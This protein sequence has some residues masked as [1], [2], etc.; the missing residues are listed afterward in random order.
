MQ[1]RPKALF[2]CSPPQWLACEIVAGDKY[3]GCC[4]C[5]HVVAMT[6]IGPVAHPLAVLNCDSAT[7]SIVSRA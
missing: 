7:T 5:H 3:A 2:E 4:R 1:P 6:D